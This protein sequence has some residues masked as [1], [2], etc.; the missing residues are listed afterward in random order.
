MCIEN[1]LVACATECVCIE[2][3]L[4]VCA[5]E[6]VCIENLLVVCAT[7]CVHREL[8]CCVWLSVCI[9]ITYLLCVPLSVCI[10]NI[11]V[12]CATKCVYT[13]NLLV[14]RVTECLFIE[15][16]EVAEVPEWE[17]SLHIL[18]FVHN[19]RTQCLLVCLALEYL[20]LY[21]PRLY[22][23]PKLYTVINE[24]KRYLYIVQ[25]VPWRTYKKDWFE[26]LWPWLK[27]IEYRFCF[28]CLYKT[29]NYKRFIG[30]K[31]TFLFGLNWI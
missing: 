22:T 2:N 9:Q 29:H 23:Q 12:V 11:L 13:E 28:P 17:V 4:V 26:L 24:F 14:V 8:T 15:F 31:S 30:S 6:C 3:L 25:S 20:F 10:E 27:S 5:T 21:C 1:L 7:E 16:E 18:L 19:T